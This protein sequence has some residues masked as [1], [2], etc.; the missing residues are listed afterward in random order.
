MIK[1]PYL[2]TFRSEQE[3]EPAA[4]LAGVK[5]FYDSVEKNLGDSAEHIDI[6]YKGAYPGHMYRWDFIRVIM[7]DKDPSRWWVFTDTPDVIFQTAMPELDGKSYRP[8][9]VASEGQRHKENPWWVNQFETVW[10]YYKNLLWDKIVYNVGSWAMRGEQATEFIDYMSKKANEP[11]VS[12]NLCE[13]AEY[14]L[15]LSGRQHQIFESPTLFTCLHDNMNNGNAR[16]NEQ[17][18]WVNRMGEPYIVVHGNGS[19][20]AYL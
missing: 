10:P 19:T 13:Q 12:Y 15:W 6:V 4:Y 17:G 2:I 14:N 3:N 8:I 9:I 5:R 7:Q 11:G 20:K 1:K 16:K 18:V